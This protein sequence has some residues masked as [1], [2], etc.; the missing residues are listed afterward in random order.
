MFPMSI[1]SISVLHTSLMIPM[2]LDPVKANPYKTLFY[3]SFD[4]LVED[5]AATFLSSFL[6]MNETS[7][8]YLPLSPPASFPSVCLYPN[9]RPSLA[10]LHAFFFH[11]VFGR[12]APFTSML[13]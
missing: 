2:E 7:K 6:E 12:P 13:V 9:L 8:I 1:N 4:P 3:L 5:N 11:I 10:H